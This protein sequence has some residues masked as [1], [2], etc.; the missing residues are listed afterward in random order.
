MLIERWG[1]TYFLALPAML[2]FVVEEQGRKP[3]EVGSVRLCLAG[4]DAV[5]VKLQERFRELFGGRS[6]SFMG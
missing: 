2:R 3:R 6:R 4:G 5:P 1:C